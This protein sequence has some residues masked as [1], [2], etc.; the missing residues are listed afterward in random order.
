MSSTNKKIK[1]SE[2]TTISHENVLSFDATDPLATQAEKFKLPDNLIYLDGN[3]LGAM[4][5]AVPAYIEDALLDGWATQL[6]TSWNNKGWHNLPFTLADRLAPMMGAK[7]GEVLLVDS[8]SLNLF[9]TLV[10]ALKMRPDRST[11][12]SEKSNFPSDIHIVQ[13][14]LDNFF[15]KKKLELSNNGDDEIISLINNQTAV[16]TLTHVDY[17]TGEIRNMQKITKAA[18]E[19]GALVIWDL[20]HS[21]GALPLDLNQ[22]NVDFAIGCSYKY[23]N[24]GHGAPAY[25]FVAERHLEH[26][27]NTLTGWMGHASPFGFDINYEPSKTI[28]KF[29][30]GTPAILSYLALEKSLDIFETINFK[31]LR[32]K[33]QNLSQLFIKLIEDK[34]ADFNLK[35]ISPRNPEMRGSQVSLT[36]PNSWEI[37]QAL[38]DHNVIGDFRA[39]NIIRFG[40]TP[41]YTSYENVWNAV[42]ILQEIIEAD[43]WKDPKY[44]VRKL[45][46]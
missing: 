32:E 35:L 19:F 5:K 12:I 40:F 4:P 29:R 46:T 43:I 17:K 31:E 22:C 38:I 18:Q 24:G 37:M 1:I 27:K 11:V 20:S 23:L 6:I 25:L 41:L 7:K 8:T 39:P 3:S 21:L 42:K 13:G 26:S 9:K 16:V 2:L 28:E 10:A 44:A 33:S 14:V 15:P 45:V 36:H 34:C 30:C